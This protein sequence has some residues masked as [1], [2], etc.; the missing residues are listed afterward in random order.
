[1]NGF[2]AFVRKEAT[3]ILRTWRILVLPGILLFFAIT[4]PVMAR[5]TP[6]ILKAVA[7]MPAAAIKALIPDPT[8]LDSYGQWAKNL[9]QIGLFALIIVYGGIV[10]SERKSGTAVL[11]LTKPVSRSA[12]IAAK[13][14]VHAAFLTVIVTAGTLVT[15]GGTALTFGSAP[16]APLLDS[17]FS[18]LVFALLFLSLMT[19]LSVALPSQAGAAGVGIGVYALLAI[20]GLSKTLTLYTPVGLSSA[21]S[22]LAS[23]KHFALLWPVLSSVAL[24]VALVAAAAWLFSRQEL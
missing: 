7:D 6:E 23:G 3:E 16:V 5:F 15:W 20:A 17:A 11:V 14:L 2:T 19:L 21:P 1:M 13:A 9:S 12:F 18:W 22:V 24:S 4:G 8:Y 10:S